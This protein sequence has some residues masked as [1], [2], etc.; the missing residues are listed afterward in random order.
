MKDDTRDTIVGIVVL[1]GM[2]LIFGI[3]LG[4]AI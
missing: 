4:M 3:G 2:G 1:V